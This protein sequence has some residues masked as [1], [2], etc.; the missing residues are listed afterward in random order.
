MYTDASDT[1]GNELVR[2]RG[3]SLQSW[4]MGKHKLVEEELTHSVIG[5]FYEVYNTLGFGFLESVYKAALERELMSRGHSVVR[6]MSIR[7]TYRGDEIAFQRLDM[8]VDDKVIIEIK[9]TFDLHKA[10]Q[11]QLYNYLRAARKEVGLLLHFGPEPE[12]Y[13][14]I[15][16]FPR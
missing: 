10:H 6:E 12:F 7:V 2:V 9:S 14:V 15:S 13:R 11:R 8:L 5:A 16:H 4:C 1:T 3:A